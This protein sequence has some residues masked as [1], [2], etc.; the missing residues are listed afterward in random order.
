MNHFNNCCEIAFNAFNGT[1][2]WIS[3]IFALILLVLVF[4]FVVKSI[5][6]RLHLH[7]ANKHQVWADSFVKAL[8]KPLSY[9]VWFFVLLRLI[10]LIYEEFSSEK[11]IGNIAVITSLGLVFA[12]VWF[13]FRWKHFVVEQMAIKHKKGELALD[14][15]RIDVI[16][17]LLTIIIVFLAAL[18]VLDVLGLNINALIAFGGV[19]G[20]AI[21]FAS[22][23]VI[24]SFFG[25]MMIYLT[26]PF[27]VSDWIVLPE[28]NVEGH[29]EAIGWYMTRVRALD[30]RLVYVPN[31]LFSKTVVINPTR[32]SHRPFK[33][34]IGLRYSDK[35][36][37]KKIIAE[38]KDMLEH[39][40][41][42]DQSMAPAIGLTSL[43]DYSLNIQ[44]I[45]YTKETS[46][47]GYL[48]VRD[49]LLFKLIEIIHSNGADLPFPTT[50][51]V[52]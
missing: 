22:Q 7:F 26:Q 20:L 43:G 6:K 11:L 1:Y 19:G 45:A 12:A 5:L 2:G 24:A 13:I 35:P 34:I 15:G 21:A 31:S 38:M 32:M 39:H 16:D 3:E 41:D 52:K 27:V 48:K 47:R 29:V 10:E 37:L 44:I 46:S 28:K 50:T 18:L 51:I 17:K 25:G 14:R 23:E 8:Y 30:K 33:E 40:P 49:D 42:I 4:N 9:Y 36:V